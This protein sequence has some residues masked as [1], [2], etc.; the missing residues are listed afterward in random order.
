VVLVVATDQ[1]EGYR[2]VGDGIG[3]QEQ[4]EAAQVEFIYA[5]RAGELL[6][7]HAA[8]RLQVE[9]GDAPAQAVVDEALREFQAEVTAHGGEDTF[10]VEAVL[11]DPVEDGIAD[12]LVVVGLGRDSERP[13]AKELATGAACFVFR[14]DDMEVCLLAV[15]EGTDTT[16]K[17]TLAMAAL[18]AVGA[19]M[20]LGGAAGDANLGHEHGLCSW[21]GRR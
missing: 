8:M 14:V 13:G 7:D 17:G 15:G 11:Q 9:A 20:S 12:P 19:G 6:Q 10:D 16:M 21:E 2:Q 3:R 18:A 5:H 4:G 1:G